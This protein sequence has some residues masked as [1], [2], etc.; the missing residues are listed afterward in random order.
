VFG[1]ILVA[2]PGALLGAGVAA[3]GAGERWER[4]RLDPIRAQGWTHT[5]GDH[6]DL[7]VTPTPARDPGIA[8][9]VS[10]R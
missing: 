8:V 9:S 6:V 7:R 10:L 1:G 2:V 4:V 3:L 5:L